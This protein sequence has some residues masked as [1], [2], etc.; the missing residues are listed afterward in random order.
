ML[1]S[2]G[3]NGQVVALHG[4]GWQEIP[5]INNSTEIGSNVESQV[6][7]TQQLLPYETSNMLLDSAGGSFRVSGD[8]LYQTFLGEAAGLWGLLRVSDDLV[9]ITQ[10]AFDPAARTTMIQGYEMANPTKGLSESMTI[11]KQTGGGPKIKLGTTSVNLANGTWNFTAPAGSVA[12]GDTV[13]VDSL[14]GGSYQTTVRS[15]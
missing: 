7:G 9:V 15:K 10:A 12:L 1:Y 8:Y 14:K 2:Q 13:I 6:F 5:F 4:H 11:S 3:D